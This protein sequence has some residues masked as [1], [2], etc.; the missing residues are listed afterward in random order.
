MKLEVIN[1]ENKSAGEVELND[2]IFAQPLR[3]DILHTVVN[4][5]LAKRRAGTQSTLTR[6]EVHGTTKKPFKQKG[7]GHARQGSLKGPHQRKGGV[8][9]APKPRDYDFKLNKKFIVKGLKVA[10]SLKIAEGNFRIIDTVVTDSPKTKDVL[11]KLSNIQVENALIV[12][13]SND[14]DN[15]YKAIQAV[16]GVDVIPQVGLNV[17]DILRHKKL[18]ITKHALEDLQKRLG[19]SNGE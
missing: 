2:D 3:K 16:H 13:G 17:Y 18:V 7:T 5:Q 11:V 1:F 14:K 12:R 6:T 8:A 15:F 10:L 4:W 19:G 9:H